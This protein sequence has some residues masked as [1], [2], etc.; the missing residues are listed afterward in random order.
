[1]SNIAEGF[2]RLSLPE[3]RQF[4]NIARASCDEVRSLSY[5]I[6]DVHPRLEP[7]T[8]SLQMDIEKCGRLIS[9]LIRSTALRTQP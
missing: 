7:A 8:Q 3:K 9:G 4:Y 5:V 1:M 6:G 2:E